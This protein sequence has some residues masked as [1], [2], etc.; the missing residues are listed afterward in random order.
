MI[1]RLLILVPVLVISAGIVVLL[2]GRSAT[3]EA[4]DGLARKQLAAQAGDVQRDVALALDQA[5][6][7]LERLRAMADPRLPIEAVAPR[8]VELMVGRP[9]VANVSIGF[10]SGL[11]RGTFV[12]PAAPGE[13][14]VQES[15]IVGGSTVR[16]NYQVVGSELRRTSS[17]TTD[18]D[19]RTRPHYT[20]AAS[21]KVRSWTPPHVYFTSK[22][23][24]VSAVEPIYGGESELAAV[25]TVDFDVA[26]LSRFID[27]SPLPGAR[28]AVISRD[29]AILAFPSAAVPPAA[30]GRLVRAED[31][32][33]PALVALIAQLA[34]RAPTHLEFLE[35]SASD[36][37]YLAS[38]TPVG[39]RRAGVEAPLDWYLAALVPEATL[40]APT[41]RMQTKSL[42]AS[43]AALM[44][45]LGIALMLAWNVMRM[46][47]DVSEAKAREQS[48]NERIR[49]LGAYRLISKLGAGGMGEV[50]RA[51][52][53]LLAREAA[54]KI[55]REDTI[56]DEDGR[57]KARARFKREAQTLAQMKSRHTIALYDYGVSDDGE[58]LYYVMELLDGVDLD[59]LVRE[60]GALPA[61]RVIAILIGA[62][63][64]LGEAH[65]AGLLH[66]DI[67]PANLFLS[68][69][70]DEVDVVKVLDFGIVHSI[71]AP[72]DTAGAAR[73][74][75]ET[76]LTREGALVGTPGFIAPEQMRG[77]RLDPRS[78]L[79]ALGCIA[80]WLFARG[81]V[82]PRPDGKAALRNHLYLPVPSLRM[83][84][85]GWLPAELEMLV[86]S[87][88]AKHP[89]DRPASAR[90]LADRLRAIEIPDEHAWS[91]QRAQEWWASYRPATS[92]SDDK[93][94]VE[95]VLATATI[96]PTNATD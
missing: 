48:A 88:L 18:Y 8:L 41:K 55:V 44:L 83:H 31:Y 68:R 3:I 24:G 72:E 59:K 96:A 7:M 85:H 67:K 81:E 28:T 58:N 94:D 90:E 86:T 91:E 2:L 39:G 87:L 14:H 22:A 37:A 13:I 34:G 43:G 21:T 42:I 78:D 71:D 64:S 32:R 40:L 46:R 33:D 57:T 6:P 16:T 89:E 35:V 4:S 63:Q 54:V 27:H 61:A 65:E 73:S 30:S 29:G 62:C 92:D 93:T 1:T 84:V 56:A 25:I 76:K 12:P 82:F 36:G 80:W 66:R 45:A 15:V 26:T 17:Q 23:T 51:Q 38:I 49:E 10:P 60:M 19:V 95:R 70:A 52:H 74:T 20:L 79:Y 9:G 69:A 5:G 47:R 53:R 75:P 50:W 77:E 11:M